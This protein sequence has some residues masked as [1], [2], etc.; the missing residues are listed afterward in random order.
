[1]R[2][3]KF[4]AW[5]LDYKVMDDNFFIQSN[6]IAHDAP[7]RTYDTPNIEIEENPNLIIMQFT[8]LQDKNGVYYCDSD[9][10]KTNTGSIEVVIIGDYG[11]DFD[12]GYD[13][14]DYY[15]GQY[16]SSWDWDK[17]EIIGNIHQNPELL[18]AK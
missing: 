1:M 15:T 14:G 7:S 8:G 2:D 4:R 9:I 13:S 3:I 16:P 18:E 5:C 6:G 10:V 17:F 11:I 12:N